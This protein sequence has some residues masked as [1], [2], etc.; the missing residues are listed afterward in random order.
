MRPHRP[1]SWII[2]ASCAL[3]VA[4]LGT[5]AAS[6]DDSEH[7]STLTQVGTY[8]YLVQPDFTG[9]AP[10][11]SILTNETLGLGTFTNLDGEL[12]LLGG[13][14]YRVRTDGTPIPAR[15]TDT[16]PFLQAIRF[17]PQLSV[18]VAPGTACADLIPVI[19]AAARSSNGIVAVRV[20]GTFTELTTRS[21]AADP[22]PFQP[23]AT[24]IAEQVVFD[25][26][27]ER[28]ALVGFRQ[29]PNAKGVGQDGLH[30]HALTADRKSGGHVLSCKAGN[31]VQLSVEQVDAVRLGTPGSVI[32]AGDG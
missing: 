15:S 29:G 21:V 13:T 18:P 9:L 19:N 27:G 28:A 1:R 24:T 11:E 16:T 4:I 26:N 17:R 2:A 7:A 5:P 14:V 12:V 20:R 23:L 3:G 8:D 31:D 32:G 10:L 22:P 6:A 30:L 25:L